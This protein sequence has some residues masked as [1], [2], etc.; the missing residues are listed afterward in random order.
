LDKITENKN[1]MDINGNT[2]K[3]NV[4]YSKKHYFIIIIAI[5]LVLIILLFIVLNPITS[6][7]EKAPDF[8][9]TDIDGN[10]FS[11]SDYYGKVIVL[12]LM[13][14]WCGPCITEMGHLK[15]I[16]QKYNQSDVIIMSID[17]DTNENNAQIRKFKVDYG[18][19]WIFA[20]DIDEVGS[21]YGVNFIPKMVII[22][23]E[24]NIAFENVGVTSSSTLSIEIDRLL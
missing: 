3:Q 22:D 16:F 20:R 8:T 15:E 12:D 9:L 7:G 21:K 11:L 14:T 18:D 2:K 17:I 4:Q 6:V 1:N 10:S 13:A 19:D 23:R 24:G 5:V